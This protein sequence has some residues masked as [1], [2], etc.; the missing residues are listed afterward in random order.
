MGTLTKTAKMSG[1]QVALDAESYEWLTGNQPEVLSALEREVS[2]GA[3]PDQI[4]LFVL[5]HTGRFELAMR[6]EQAA[7]HVLNT[8]TS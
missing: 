3:T 1:L 2:G 5:R 4:K 7:R 6:C 8:S